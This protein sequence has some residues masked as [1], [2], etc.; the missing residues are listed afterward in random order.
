MYKVAVSG[1]LKLKGSI[2]KNIDLSHI[3]REYI[4]CDFFR[5]PEQVSGA[6]WYLVFAHKYPNINLFCRLRDNVILIGTLADTY[7][8]TGNFQ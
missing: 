4:I 3:L 1:Q 5:H 2:S 6:I 7:L 8:C